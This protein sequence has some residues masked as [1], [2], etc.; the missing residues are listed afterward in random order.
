MTKLYRAVS[1]DE[2]DDI[3][4][5]NEFR[6]IPYKTLE[7]KQFATSWEDAKK[8]GDELINGFENQPYKIIEIEINKELLQNYDNLIL[9]VRNCISVDIDLLEEFNKFVIINLSYE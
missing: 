6:I 2:F 8:F 7:A 4:K 3:K 9:D 1:K 5:H